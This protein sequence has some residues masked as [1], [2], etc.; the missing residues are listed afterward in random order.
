MSDVNDMP[1]G[2]MPLALAALV[3]VAMLML[4]AGAMLA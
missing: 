1:A 4:A 3:L 2:I